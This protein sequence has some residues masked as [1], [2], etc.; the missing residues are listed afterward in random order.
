MHPLLLLMLLLLL[1]Q[2]AVLSFLTDPAN[3]YDQLTAALPGLAPDQADQLLTL[4]GLLACNMLQHC[5]Q[6]R[7]NVDF[8]INRCAVKLCN[9]KSCELHV[10]YK[11]VVCCYA[12]SLSYANVRSWL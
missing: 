9:L 6:K 3:S 2:D 8:G 7:H 4:R 1:L 12:H 11:E 5:L 10:A